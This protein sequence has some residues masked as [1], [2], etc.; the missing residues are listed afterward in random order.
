MFSALIRGGYHPV[1]SVRKLCCHPCPYHC[2]PSGERLSGEV[3]VHVR[4]IRKAHEVIA[5]GIP[6]RYYNQHK[7]E[8]W[9]QTAGMFEVRAFRD[10]EPL[11]VVEGKAI[12]VNLVSD[13]DGPYDFWEFDPAIGNWV[14][15]ASGNVPT[16]SRMSGNKLSREIE[17]LKRELSVPLPKPKQ[18][19]VYEYDVA[20]IDI[21]C[22]P[23]LK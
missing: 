6:M 10:G 22:C 17:Q 8:E 1:P 4:E 12:E 18:Y 23:E 11:K 14:K 5:S 3:E 20:D 7:Q 13:A 19:E 16:K 9:F 15:R 21:S 2:L